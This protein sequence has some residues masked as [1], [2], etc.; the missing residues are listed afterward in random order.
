MALGES[1]RR[2]G[3]Q[4]SC[5]LKRSSKK[6]AALMSYSVSRSDKE[7]RYPNWPTGARSTFPSQARIDGGVPRLLSR[8]VDPFNDHAASVRTVGAFF[9]KYSDPD[10]TRVDSNG[11][12]RLW[13]DLHLGGRSDKRALAILW[14]LKG[15]R[16]DSV[17]RTGFIDGCLDLNTDSVDRLRREMPNLLYDARRN[18]KDFYRFVFRVWTATT[19]QR[20]P[21]GKPCLSQTDAIALWKI[22]LPLC[23]GDALRF[24][25]SWYDFLNE[26]VVETI[27]ESCWIA[28]LRFSQ[29]VLK[30]FSNFAAVRAH[31]WPSVLTEFATLQ[32]AKQKT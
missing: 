4:F 2:H 5:T 31:W 9:C 3:S 22:V 24:E 21:S 6:I 17:S 7:A 12:D 20:D 14:R 13:R 18:F 27:D 16:T 29:A 25:H 8:T 11:L 30:D 23:S 19:E 26:S 10:G 15:E 28:Y 1:A 32:T